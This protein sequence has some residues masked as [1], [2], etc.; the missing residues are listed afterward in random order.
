MFLEI[1]D[2]TKETVELLTK[3]VNLYEQSD[4]FK[5]KKSQLIRK[6]DIAEY[7]K[8]LQK[9]KRLNIRLDAEK[10][11]NAVTKA[12][13]DAVNAI[14]S[15]N[16]KSKDKK[17][18]IVEEGSEKKLSIS[19]QIKAA[20]DNFKTS[21][22][23]SSLENAGAAFNSV[24]TAISDKYDVFPLENL[25]KT[26]LNAKTDSEIKEVLVAIGEQFNPVNSEDNES[27]SIYAANL[28]NKGKTSNKDISVFMKENFPDL[29]KFKLENGKSVAFKIGSILVE[30]LEILEE[31][32][33]KADIEA[34]KVAKS[35]EVDT[36]PVL[37]LE[38]LSIYKENSNEEID[39]VPS[40]SMT[41]EQIDDT[42]NKV[43]GICP[44]T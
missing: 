19:E 17:E 36:Q 12:A 34:A 18:E 33:E 28:F 25:N 30:D 37:S 7:K 10:V 42:L 32:K 14:K 8:R 21:K 24:V 22:T 9:Q 40:E 44:K 20:T 4:R 39:I 1:R 15:S 26:F 11:D 38:Q 23:F 16:K 41:E 31:L 13:Q 29:A 6:T 3:A 43:P 2:N 27:V 5:T 35:K